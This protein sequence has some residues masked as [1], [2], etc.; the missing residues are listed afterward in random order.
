MKAPRDI[1]GEELAKLL[2]R[3]GYRVTRRTG[4]HIRLTTT[5]QGEHH[6]TIPLHNPLRIGTLNNILNDIAAHLRISKEALSK[7]LFIR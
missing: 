7:E 3:Y 1:R 5:E 6:V 2:G 4:S